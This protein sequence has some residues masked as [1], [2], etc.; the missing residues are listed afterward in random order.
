VLATLIR[1]E[2]PDPLPWLL[3]VPRRQVRSLQLAPGIWILRT[4]QWVHAAVLDTHSELP[5][6]VVDMDDVHP[7]HWPIPDFHE[8]A[9]CGGMAFAAFF[10]AASDERP[11]MKRSEITYA[12][13]ICAACPVKRDCLDWALTKGEAFGVW[14]G[15][16]GRQRAR[17]RGVMKTGVTQ[18]KIIDG[19]FSWWLTTT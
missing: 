12:R 4:R 8:W 3:D 5:S 16:S 18:D 2:C 15:T 19:W 17:M 6:P 1:T 9:L 13:G 10:G 14:G 11:T 7:H